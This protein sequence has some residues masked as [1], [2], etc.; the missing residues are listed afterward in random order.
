MCSSRSG[1]CVDRTSA[2]IE[3]PVTRTKLLQYCRD[4]AVDFQEF[5]SCDSVTDWL[6][7]F[8]EYLLVDLGVDLRHWGRVWSFLFGVRVEFCGVVCVFF[9]VDLF[10][11]YYFCLFYMS[12]LVHLFKILHYVYY[13]RHV[14]LIKI[15]FSHWLCWDRAEQGYR[16]A[17]DF[18]E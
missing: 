3:F 4:S 12:V 14:I 9:Q 16:A 1:E 11:G 17:C 10:H 6:I 15:P 5:W 2:C 18:T 7:H 13:F 8:T